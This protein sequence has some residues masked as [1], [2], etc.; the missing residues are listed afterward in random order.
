MQ[1][2]FAV[3]EVVELKSGGPKMTVTS[4]GTP[5]GVPTVGCMWFEGIKKMQGDFPP[6]ALQAA[7]PSKIGSAVPD[8][9]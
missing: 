4:V 1:S 8:E 9:D 2:T 7:R 5:F 6:G 3:G